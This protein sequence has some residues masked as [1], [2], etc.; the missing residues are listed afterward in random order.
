MVFAVDA[1]SYFS[2]PS[3]RI[4]TGIEILAKIINPD[5]FANLV[6]PENSYTR[7]RNDA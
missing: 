1:M 2:R 5:S 4:I 6:I 3:P 7:L